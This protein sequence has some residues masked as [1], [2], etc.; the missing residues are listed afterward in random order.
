M[1]ILKGASLELHELQ[2]EHLPVLFL[3]R[4]S[5]DFMGLC[6]TRRN[7]IS[8]EEFRIELKSDFRRD[9]HS[10]FLIIK[11]KE[12]IG[13]VYS[14]KLNRTDGYTFITIFIAKPWRNKGYGAEAMVVFLEYLFRE[15]G[16]Y[17][18]YAEIYSYNHKSL[19]ALMSGKF[20][21]EGR[22]RG[23]RL[24]HE[25]RHDLI[26]LAFFRSQLGD[27]ASLVKKLTNRDLLAWM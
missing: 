24:Y 20:I 19:R 27:F 11:K 7:L 23:H 12:C 18:V 5:V 10:Q 26:R 9:R 3:W 25:E 2:E 17:K 1:R 14:Y 21:E 16:L 4:N 8:P 22:F 13:T 15:F 6:S